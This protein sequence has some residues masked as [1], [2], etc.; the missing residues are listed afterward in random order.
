VDNRL[1]AGFANLS[2]CSFTTLRILP[3]GALEDAWQPDDLHRALAAAGVALWSWNVESDSFAMDPRAFGLWGLVWSREV[4][5]EELSE[6][7]HPADRDRVRAAFAATRAI[8]GAYET[9]FRIT[10]NKE[11]RWISA[12]GQGGDADIKGQVMFGIFLDVTGRKQAE[13][14]HELLAGEMSHRVKNLLAI[15]SALTQLTSRSAATTFDMAHDLTQRLSS[16]GRAHDLVRP[17]P[18]KQDSAAL[19]GDLLTLLLAPYDD[20]GA[21]KGR[22]KISVERMGIGE[23]GATTLALVIHELATNALKYGALSADTGSLNV[24]GTT[25][26]D[27]TVLVWAERG[28]PIVTAPDSTT[29]FGSK[30]IARSMTCKLGG[31][32]AYD[33]SPD[34]LIVTLRM[35]TGRLMA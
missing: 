24:S 16:L 11:I 8:A 19:L 20:P 34:G 17:L 14:S 10:V 18:G 25:E 30:L 22:I 4:T 13:E 35:T 5:F 31:S 3:P 7:I 27:Q 21:F 12:R 33:W 29:G 28:G 6:H 9:D 1:R 26:A 15:A 2:Y 23:A 32:V